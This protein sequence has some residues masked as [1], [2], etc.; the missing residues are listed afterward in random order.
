MKLFVVLFLFEALATLHMGQSLP[1]GRITHDGLIID[2][3][4]E[5]FGILG[6]PDFIPAHQNLLRKEGIPFANKYRSLVKRAFS[7]KRKEFAGK[8]KKAKVFVKA[9]P[10]STKHA[11]KAVAKAGGKRAVTS[12]MNKRN[13]NKRKFKREATNET[14]QDRTR[15]LVKRDLLGKIKDFGKKVKKA[16][17]KAKHAVKNLAKDKVEKLMKK[18]FKG[19][20]RNRRSPDDTTDYLGPPPRGLQVVRQ[21]IRQGQENQERKMN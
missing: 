17:K 13:K 14:N 12:I 15:S 10:K 16:A 4:F 6:S 7:D 11:L 1:T 8:A 3:A 21:V 9:L 5:V 19:K 20:K 2:P 18:K